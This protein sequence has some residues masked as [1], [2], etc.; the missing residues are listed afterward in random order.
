MSPRPRRVL[1][2]APDVFFLARIRATAEALGVSIEEATLENAAGACAAAPPD[3]IVLDLHASGDPMT[4]ARALKSHPASQPV[5]I[6]GFYSH[7]D[8]AT[9]EAALS[10]GVDRV[11]PRSAFTAK[12]AELLRGD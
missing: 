12:L 1:V 11:M 6:V 7:V 2:V 3:L 4:L 5:P 10:A 9:R 8:A